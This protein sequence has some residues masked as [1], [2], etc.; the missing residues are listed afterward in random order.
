MT[1]IRETTARV[2]PRSRI[3]I[4]SPLIKGG[5]RYLGSFAAIPIA[6]TSVRIR[7]GKKMGTS[8]LKA[9][10]CQNRWLVVRYSGLKNSRSCS[11]AS[12]VTSEAAYGAAL[13]KI[14]LD[15]PEHHT[16]LY[17]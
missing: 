16:Q 8:T 11:V 13:S 10:L 5:I 15:S 2:V 6:K 17:S 1:E 7:R 14:T 12:R 4:E 9:V 3:R